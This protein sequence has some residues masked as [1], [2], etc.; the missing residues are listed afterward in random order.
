MPSRSNLAVEQGAEIVLAHGWPNERECQELWF[1]LAQQSWTSIVIVPAD[2][3]GSSAALASA[4]ADVGKR[5]S[6]NPVTAITFSALEYDTARALADVQRHIERARRRSAPQR[7]SQ[8]VEVSATVVDDDDS[9]GQGT[10]GSPRQHRGVSLL[11]P[12][13][14]VIISIPPVVEEPLGLAFAHAA[15]AV[16][17]LV[18]RGVTRYADARRSIELIGRERIAG[19]FLLR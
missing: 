8:V 18:E 19:C 9:E 17:L 7:N 16:V 4:L 2:R 1:A 5:V 6:E 12:D 13:G 10:D 15:D 3:E 14:Q 11:D